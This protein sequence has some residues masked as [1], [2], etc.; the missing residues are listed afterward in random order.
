MS[1]KIPDTSF[2][3]PNEINSHPCMASSRWLN[4]VP[5]TV[6]ITRVCQDSSNPSLVII[7]FTLVGVFLFTPSVKILSVD[8]DTTYTSNNIIAP[9]AVGHFKN[10][11]V[12]INTNCNTF[13]GTLVF[14]F[15]KSILNYTSAQV[16]VFELVMDGQV[17][18]AFGISIPNQS[19]SDIYTWNKGVLPSPVG[20]TYDNNGNLSISFE[21]KGN[22]DCTCDIQ[23]FI[24]SG[25]STEINFCPDEVKQVTLYQNPNQADPYSVVLQLS[26]SLGNLSTL[27]FQSL[28]TTKPKSP[29]VMS[30]T[31]PKRVNVFISKESQNSVQIENK[32]AYQ[33]IKYEGSKSNNKIWKDWSTA[34]WNS[35]VD[36]EIIPGQKYGYAVRYK[37]IFGEVSKISDWAELTI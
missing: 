36:Y 28:F 27:E 16:I 15:S 1:T 32:A 10:S 19:C 18:S 20:L 6:N 30:D 31:K 11:T 26:D 9:F 21:Y 13:Y 33:I 7:D 12:P 29:I 4:L 2:S 5:E 14:D 34:D 24:P 23:C 3:G 22:I 25:V 37:G 8:G 17:P 35:F